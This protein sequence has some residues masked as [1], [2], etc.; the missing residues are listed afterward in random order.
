[1]KFGPPRTW[2]LARLARIRELQ[3]RN[4]EARDLYARAVELEPGNPEYLVCFGLVSVALKQYDASA[5]AFD[6]C[7][8]LMPT[9]VRVRRYAMGAYQLAGNDQRA[10]DLLIEGVRAGIPRE[11]FLDPEPAAERPGY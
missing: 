10:K 4:A 11:Q 9:N 6:R 5:N 1:M 3:G 8:R 2:Q 7:V